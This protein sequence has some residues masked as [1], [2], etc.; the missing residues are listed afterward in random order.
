MTEEMTIAEILSAVFGEPVTLVDGGLR[1]KDAGT[2]WVDVMRMIF[3]WRVTRTPKDHPETA[4]RAWCYYGAGTEA[5]LR[6]VAAAR[7]WD[8]GDD[9]APDGWDK[10]AMTGEYA[11]LPAWERA[12]PEWRHGR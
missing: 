8:G 5:L 7:D 4:D 10:D 12:D 3:S 11:S 2:H 9:T 6:A 1:V